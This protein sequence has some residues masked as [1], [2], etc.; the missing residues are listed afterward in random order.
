MRRFHV[1]ILGLVALATAPLAAQQPV[2]ERLDMA[3]LARIRDEGLNHSRVDSMAQQ[4]LDGIGSRLTA[5]PGLRRAQE[6]AVGTMRGWGLVNVALEPWDSLFGRGWERVSY[7]GRMIEPVMQPLRAEP[8][9]WSGSTPRGAAVTCPVV[10]INIQDTTELAQYAGRVRGACVM[11]QNWNPIGPEFTFAPR[12]ID[13]DTLIWLAT[14]PVPE[15]PRRQAGPPQPSEQM[16]Q[17]QAVQARNAAIMRFLRREQPAVY[18]ISSGWTMGNLRTGGHLDGRLA[19][20]SAYE[21]IPQLMVTHEQYGQMWRLARRGVPVRLEVNVQN[22]WSNPDKREYTVVGELPGTDRAQELVIIGAHFDSWHSG[23]GAVDNAAGSLAMMEA[24]RILRT[25]NLPLRRTVRIALWS[26]E[27]QGLIGS[28]HYVRMHAA[29]QPRI[30]AYLNIDNGSGRLRGVWGER[31]AAAVQVFEQILRPFADLG[32]VTS[33]LR[34]TGGTDHM[35][36]DRAGVPGFQFIQDPLEYGNRSHH[37]A[38]DTYERL[39]MD[40]LKQ[41]ATI[42]AWSVYT[43]A[44]RDEMMPRKMP[45]PMGTN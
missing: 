13:A 30:S 39:V 6:W 35:S 36:F 31:N 37:S 9:A 34:P 27:E 32:V 22:R 33:N 2:Q 17:F 26:G 12:R 16:R 28:R 4:L 21:P 41:A 29:E 1:L 15:Q 24:M 18:L 43:I 7:S 42:V 45:A 14:Q 40:D 5:S 8:M 23:Q 19:R 38:Q 11:W 3:A 25:L 20:D 44:N 10:Y